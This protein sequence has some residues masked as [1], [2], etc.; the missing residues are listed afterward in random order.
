M[1]CT[2][3]ER[4]YAND[5]KV[6]AGQIAVHGVDAGTGCE[7][8]G[9]VLLDAPGRVV[10]PAGPCSRR[11]SSE[12]LL[13]CRSGPCKAGRPVWRRKH[14]L[15]R[16]SVTPIA[17][18]FRT[19]LRVKSRVHGSTEPGGAAG[20]VRYN[21][22]KIVDNARQ[23]Q[24]TQE[25]SYAGRRKGKEAGCDEA[26]LPL[27]RHSAGR[28]HRRGARQGSSR[29][30]A[31]DVEETDALT[32]ELGQEILGRERAAIGLPYPER[33]RWLRNWP[34]TGQAPPALAM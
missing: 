31:V 28:E 19:R 4:W 32:V 18:K 6:G 13:E 29:V 1:A 30:L 21:A 14:A 15:L 7:L 9:H 8:F 27:G 2:H 33:R 23:G 3:P 26:N 34:R 10:W 24:E 22:G 25:P 20:R 12:T 17:G 16:A 11:R 5:C